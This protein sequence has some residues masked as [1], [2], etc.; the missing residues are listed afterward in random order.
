MKLRVVLMF[1]SSIMS[2]PSGTSLQPGV[3]WAR[4][5]GMPVALQVSMD[6][7]IPSTLLLRVSPNLTS[8]RLPVR[9]Q[10]GQ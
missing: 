10:W 6:S 3:R 9:L 5:V 1:I 7:R 8:L 2:L 4:W